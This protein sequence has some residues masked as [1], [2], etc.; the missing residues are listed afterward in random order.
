MS[1]PAKIAA[2]APALAA[3]RRDLHRH[4]E[5]AFAETR[6]ADIVAREL[7]AC[8]VEVTRGVART[9]VVGTLRAGSGA[10]AIALRADMDC[11]P[12][13][14]LN[15]FAHRSSH[16]GRMH[17]CGHDGH[18]TMLLGAARHLA[19]TRSFD[20]T[21]HF[22]FQ[23]AEEMAG[24]GKVMVEEGLF[25]RF[26]ADAVF[27][28]HNLPGVAA[29]RF[30]MRVGPIMAAIDEF[31][32]VIRG[33]GG[34]AAF[35][36]LAIDPVLVQAHVVTALQ[37]IVSRQLDPLDNAVLTITQVHGG[38]AY[39]VIPESVVLRGTLRSFEA[40]VRE[41]A[42][43]ALRRICEQIC[44]GFGARAEISYRRLYPATVNTATETQ[45]AARAAARVVGETNVDTETAPLMGSED[46]AYMLQA[47]PG[48]YIFIGNG[49]GEGS[50][51][52]HSP[53][54]DFNDEILALGASYWVSLVEQ[55]LAPA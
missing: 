2:L 52:L 23:P 46:F 14:E 43:A 5:L 26:P 27:G 37:S 48:A 51:M 29:G 38:D 7:I 1:I 6:T 9:G 40:A 28:M 10:R 32:V 54:Y 49:A 18:T 55:E 8:G 36:H 3:I 17:A 13:V 50:C 21:V 41:R 33:A 47:K 4:P 12:L 44:A 39:N 45:R 19:A 42:E 11:L 20:G 53:R 16:E 25:E 15:E 31:E 35:P 24:G 30:A 34:H 22:I